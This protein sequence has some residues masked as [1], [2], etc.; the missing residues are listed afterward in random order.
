MTIRIEEAVLKNLITNEVYTRKVFPFLKDVYFSDN[1]EQLI[2]RE[3]QSFVLKYNNLPSYEALGIA[4]NEAPKIPQLVVDGAHRILKE[5]KVSDEKTDIK[6]LLDNTE[7]FCKNM[8][9]HNA[10]GESI[11]ILDGNKSSS[12]GVGAIPSIL[13][14]A[15]AV[16]FDTNV[17][18]DYFEDAE[19]RFDFYHKKERKIPF[20]IEY[21]NRITRGGIEPKTLNIIMGGVN[22]GKTLILCH[23]AA[24]YVAQGFNVLYITLEMA[25]EKIAERIDA[26]LLNI[27]MEDLEKIPKD[28]FLK[29]VTNLKAK[30][31]GKFKIKEFPTCGASTIHF[32][33]L[34]NELALKQNFKPDVIMLDYLNLCASSRLKASSSGEMYS[35]V[36]AIAEEIRGLAQ[37]TDIG[38]W[39]ATQS[40]RKGFTSSDPGLEDVAESFGLP[41]TADFFAVI[42]SSEEMENLSQFEVKQLKNRYGDKSKNKRFCIG[43]DYTKMRVYDVEESGQK[44]VNANQVPASKLV[45]PT[46]SGAVPA[47]VVNKFSG[48]TV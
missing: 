18:H 21:L 31:V 46:N 40:N 16:S 6:W 12:K 45:P 3:V 43:V 35:Y 28:V 34:L 8:A 37:E 42:I 41:A 20:D 47:P 44:L 9:I 25:Q 29:K 17:G 30:N 4:I 2:F 24:G 39:S 13:Q 15:L 27:A 33:A 5:L 7:S 19:E 14:E 23:M 10:L 48:L 11:Q 36:K 38:I 22:V 32:K 1:S 26:N